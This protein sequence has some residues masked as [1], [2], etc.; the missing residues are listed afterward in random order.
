MG[1]IFSNVGSAL[2]ERLR[3]RADSEKVFLVLF[4]I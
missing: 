1:E 4:E 3:N 2:F